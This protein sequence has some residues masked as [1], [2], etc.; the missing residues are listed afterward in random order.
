MINHILHIILHTANDTVYLIPYL[1]ITYLILEYIEHHTHSKIN[2]FLYQSHRFAPFYGAV[3]APLSGCGLSAVAANFYVTRLIS[4]GTLIAIYLAT[5]DEMLPLLIAGG[6]PMN[7]IVPLLIFKII[8]AAAIGF[9]QIG[10]A[11]V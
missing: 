3:L 4:L 9:M 6:I 7:V 8:F 2:A 11:H 5:S 1:Y 10:R